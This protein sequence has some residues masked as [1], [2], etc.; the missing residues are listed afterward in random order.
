M[1]EQINE[2]IN[3]LDAT[4]NKMLEIIEG[5]A[6]GMAADV[7]PPPEQVLRTVRATP[8]PQAEKPAEFDI[9]ELSDL[10]IEQPEPAVVK[11][12]G[13]P[14]KNPQAAP[15]KQEIQQPY[16]EVDDLLD[17]LTLEAPPTRVALA[18]LPPG[19]AAQSVADDDLNFDDL[20][21]GL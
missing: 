6:A 16:D 2:S 14:P 17:G 18:D 20:L 19:L 12:R 8:P 15:A 21:E 11:R 9:G 4:M 3:R 10:G 13:R 7:V 1:L 5:F